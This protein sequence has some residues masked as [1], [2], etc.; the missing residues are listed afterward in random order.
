MVGIYRILNTETGESYIGQSHDI[1]NRIQHHM[2]DMRSENSN[3]I[4]GKNLKLYGLDK[5]EIQIVEECAPEYLDSYERYYI[6]YYD[7]IKN[8]YNLKE[9]GQD[10]IGMSNPRAS[11]TDQ[12]VYNIRESYKNHMRKKEVFEIYSNKMTWMS[13]SNLW[14]GQSWNHIHMDVYTEDNKLYYSKQA[15]NGDLSPNALYT[16]EEVIQLRNRY[17]NESAKE[18]YKDYSDRCGFQTFQQ[19]LWGRTYYELPIYDKRRK[20]WINN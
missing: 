5:F 6:N 19:M 11:L 3:T 14:E 7:S 17:V 4:I 16:N 9:G 10:N 8:G 1:E 15:T 12:D 13:F 18:I 20:V 2:S